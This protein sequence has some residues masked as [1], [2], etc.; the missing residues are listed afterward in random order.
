MPA[1]AAAAVVILNSYGFGF[2]LPVAVCIGVSGAVEAAPR[3]QRGVD[4]SRGVL[5]L[6]ASSQGEEVEP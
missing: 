5:E 3:W 2:C 6:F 1:A 4:G